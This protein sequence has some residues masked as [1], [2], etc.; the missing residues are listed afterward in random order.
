MAA[1]GGSK[2]SLAGALGTI[3]IETASSFEPVAEAYYLGAGAEAWRKANLRYWPYYGRGYCQLTWLETYRAAGE[4]I[5]VDLVSQPDRAME[6][7][8]AAQLFAWFWCIY[9]PAV[10][11]QA[12]QRNWTETRRLVQGGSDGLTRLVTVAE[13]LLG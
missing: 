6:P 1:G 4:Y 11:Y 10:L 9:K 3:C 7:A 12:D 2:N 13:A 5:G 8:I